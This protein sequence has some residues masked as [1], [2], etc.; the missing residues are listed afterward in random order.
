MNGNNSLITVIIPLYNAEKYIEETIQSVI[1]QTYKNWELLVVAK[2]LKINST[3][4]ILI[5]E[6][7]NNKIIDMVV[8]A[9]IKKLSKYTK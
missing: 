4:T 9:D 2:K 5:V 6:K 7:D 3:P 1:N 8:G